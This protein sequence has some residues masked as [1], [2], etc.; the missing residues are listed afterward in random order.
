MKR[1]IVLLAVFVITITPS[2]AL[3]ESSGWQEGNSIV[4]V[5]TQKDGTHEVEYTDIKT[6]KVQKVHSVGSGYTHKEVVEQYN[7]G[8]HK[9]THVQ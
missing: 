8:N 1:L 6:D 2:I 4:T 9:V 3:S 5:T 7:K